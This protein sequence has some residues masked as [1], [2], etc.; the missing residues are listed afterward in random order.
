MTSLLQQS[1][2]SAGATTRRLAASARSP[3]RLSVPAAHAPRYSTATSP[4]KQPKI[5][6][7]LTSKAPAPNGRK[8]EILLWEL[9]L[10]YDGALYLCVYTLKI[11]ESAAIMLHLGQHY[12]PERKFTFDPQTREYTEMPAVDLLRPTHYCKLKQNMKYAKQ[13]YIDET[14]RLYGVLNVRLNGREWL[15][16]SGRGKY[17]IADMN[18]YPWVSAHASSGIES[19]D[20][21][22]RVKAWLE[23]TWERQAVRVAM[24]SRVPR[25]PAKWRE[26]DPDTDRLGPA[27]GAQNHA[28]AWAVRHAEV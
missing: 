19:M 7:L 18:A 27:S 14:K 11:C 22:P 23:R 3:P 28:H 20:E 26:L 12:D 8:V 16:G 2:R 24:N 21:W 17:S 6:L 15:A 25:Q 10:Q 4:P 9:Q 13:R 5:L 1:L